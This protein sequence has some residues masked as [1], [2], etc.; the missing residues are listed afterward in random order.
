M[1]IV[2]VIT[3][4]MLAMGIYCAVVFGESSKSDAL[5]IVGMGIMFFLIVIAGEFVARSVIQRVHPRSIEAAPLPK[6]PKKTDKFEGGQFEMKWGATYYAEFDRP[7][8]GEYGRYH[9]TMSDNASRIQYVGSWWINEDGNLVLHEMIESNK[10]TSW[11]YVFE[12]DRARD[13]AW[14]LRSKLSGT[15]IEFRPP[16][17]TP[18]TGLVVRLERQKDS[19]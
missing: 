15:S 2:I 7:E 10:S 1:K 6:T 14:I 9:A 16:V 11:T 3:L 5:P 12:I 19:E 17:L 8:N 18:H 13:G 4:A